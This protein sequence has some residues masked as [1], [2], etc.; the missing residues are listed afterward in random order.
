MSY[1]NSHIPYRTIPTLLTSVTSDMQ[2]L[3]KTLTYLLTYLHAAID[4]RITGSVDHFVT[5]VE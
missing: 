4:V 1:I 3:R 5:V 2:R